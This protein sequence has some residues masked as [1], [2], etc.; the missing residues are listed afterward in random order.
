MRRY[1][2]VT[3]VD[4]ISFEVAAGQVVGFLGPNGAGKTTTL[5]ILAGCLRPTSGKVAVA[6]QDAAADAVDSRALIGYLPENNP[7]YEDM[8]VCEYLRWCAGARGLS[9]ADTSRAIA[10]A[11]ERCGLS[12]VAGRAIGELSKGYRQRVGL[13]AA[14]VHDPPVL[15]LDEPTAGLDPNQAV[16]IRRLIVELGRE[17]AVL[18]SSHILP[19]VKAAC[20]RALVIHKGK[21]AAEVPQEEL[22]RLED[23][24]RSLT[25]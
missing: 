13:A 3:A 24:F 21:I 9:A 12:E 11:V 5:R 15:L 4:G 17:K 6:G 18:F 20:S 10:R 25:A 8:E 2:P 7:L 1:G 14:I 16:E 23:V 22:E 19:E